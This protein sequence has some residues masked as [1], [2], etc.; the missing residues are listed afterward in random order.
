MNINTHTLCLSLLTTI[1]AACSAFGSNADLV[2]Q[3]DVNGNHA[4]DNPDE[5]YLGLEYKLHPDKIDVATHPQ[6][7]KNTGFRSKRYRRRFGV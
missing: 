4:I 7:R 1:G 5:V 3:L 2:D 6:D